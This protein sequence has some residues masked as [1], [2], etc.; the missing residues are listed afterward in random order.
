MYSS[1]FH[2]TYKKLTHEMDTTKYGVTIKSEDI[3]LQRKK[4]YI[5]HSTV[6]TLFFFTSD[7]VVVSF[8][9]SMKFS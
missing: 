8:V 3:A 5:A 7:Y 4:T 2:K 6:R 9:D 1:S